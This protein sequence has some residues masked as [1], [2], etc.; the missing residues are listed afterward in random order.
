MQYI[1]TGRVSLTTEGIRAHRTAGRVAVPSWTQQVHDRP[2]LHTEEGP[3]AMPDPMRPPRNDRPGQAPDFSDM[4]GV[5]TRT[6]P[7]LASSSGAG[8]QREGHVS[9]AAATVLK[10]P[11]HLLLAFFLSH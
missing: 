9:G 2:G 10:L 8:A 1:L 11:L 3:L 4:W 6:V 5:D 7:R